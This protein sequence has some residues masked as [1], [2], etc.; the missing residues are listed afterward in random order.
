[1]TITIYLKGRL[2]NQLFQYATLRNISIKKGY[3]FY[4][5]KNFSDHGQSVLLPYFNIPELQPFTIHNYQYNQPIDSYFFDKT[6]FD[7][8]DNTMIIGFFENVEYFKE[9][10]DIIRNDLCIK[11]DYINNYSN[12][13]LNSI[14]KD[15]YK[16]VG[17]HFRRGD[18]LKVINHYTDYN[19]NIIDFNEIEKKFVYESLNS[20]MKT[21]SKITLLLFTGGIRKDLYESHLD[22]H[23][24][25]NDISWVRDFINEFKQNSE[26][27]NICDIHISPG[28]IEN[29]EVIDFSLLGKCDYIITPHQSTFSFMSYYLSKKKIQMYS[30]TNLYGGLP[31]NM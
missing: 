1:M 30:R 5:N 22:N 19:N 6:I 27:S 28:T 17:I 31:T 18:L 4:I 2:G 7:I 29:N 15:D 20:I 25:E 23:T 3:N 8:N 9:N 13:F 26:F 24:Q 12:N 16:L 21:E 14:I 10:I 11:D